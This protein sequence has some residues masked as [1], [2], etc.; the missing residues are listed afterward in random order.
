[1]I[2]RNRP[3]LSPGHTNAKTNSVEIWRG[4]SR[5]DGA[6]IVCIASGL[7]SSTNRKTGAMVQ[8]YILRRDVD[9]MVALKSGADVSICGGCIHRPGNVTGS[10]YSDRSC[11]VNVGQGPLSVW[12]AWNRGN[13]PSVALDIVPSLVAGRM[14]R[15]GT[16]GDPA[17]VPLEVWDA[18][19]AKSKGW[20]G[21]THQARSRKLRDVLKY[22]QVSAD[23]PQDAAAARRA[24]IGS[25]RVLRDGESPQKFEAICPASAEAGRVATCETCG[26]CRG[27][28]GANVAIAAHGIGAPVK[29]DR[30]RPIN[31]STWRK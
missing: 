10:S 4:A 5:I 7:K 9:P 3:I 29:I 26:I 18:Y 27:V 8:T 24:G 14:V 25:F 1:M 11:Y 2:K 22:C 23:T 13:V 17:A 12:R 31:L 20:T 16:Y 6:P 21:Y 15:L 30:R 19:T 28:D